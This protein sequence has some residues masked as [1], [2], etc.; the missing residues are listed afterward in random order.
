MVILAVCGEHPVAMPPAPLADSVRERS[1]VEWQRF[2]DAS[3][4]EGFHNY[5]K[6]QYLDRFDASVLADFAS[7]ISSPLSDIKLWELNHPT[8]NTGA[9]GHRAARL[10]LN[11]NSRWAD[12]PAEPHVEW[13]RELWDAM[14]PYSSGGVYVNFLGAEGDDRVREA[15]GEENWARLVE[16]KRRYDPDN[17]FR[18]NQNISLG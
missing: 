15:Y 18:V 3:W 2:S 4:A 16:L 12:G 5:W 11:V 10:L 8:A 13:T 14:L 17:V 1:Y 7:R 9:F 6:A